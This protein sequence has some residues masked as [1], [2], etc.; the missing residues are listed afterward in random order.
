M[1]EFADFLIAFLCAVWLAAVMV[2]V[3]TFVLEN[4]HRPRLPEE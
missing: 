3:I 4:D 2:R 1:N